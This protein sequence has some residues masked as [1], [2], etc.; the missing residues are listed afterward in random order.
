MEQYVEAMIAEEKEQFTTDEI[1][2][3]IWLLK[4]KADT[5]SLAKVFVRFD[6]IDLILWLEQ[7]ME[8]YKFDILFFTM[9][10]INDSIRCSFYFFDKEKFMIDQNSITVSKQIV[11]SI[12]IS[13]AFLEMKIYLLQN[14]FENAQAVDLQKLLDVLKKKIIAPT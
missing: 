3:F 8:D 4:D 11:E 13:S 14:Y 5:F 6:R 12:C 10:I 9:A 7:K 1:K 2:E